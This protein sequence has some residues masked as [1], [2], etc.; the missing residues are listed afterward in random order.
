MKNMQ[1]HFFS[2]VSKLD[3]LQNTVPLSLSSHCSSVQE[4]LAKN[5][6]EALDTVEH[7]GLILKDQNKAVTFLD[8]F[9]S[10]A[11]PS[12]ASVQDLSAFLS[13]AESPITN[14][15]SPLT[16]YSFPFQARNA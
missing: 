4:R 6:S 14:H 16:Y 10:I 2:F 12:R 5:G 9:G 15:Q 3:R 7:S 8:H 11:N 13:R 1:Q